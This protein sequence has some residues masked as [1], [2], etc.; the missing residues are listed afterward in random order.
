[1]RLNHCWLYVALLVYTVWDKLV[2]CSSCYNVVAN[3]SQVHPVLWNTASKIV[4]VHVSLADKQE[5]LFRPYHLQSQL[6]LLT[7]CCHEYS[8]DDAT[9]V[10]HYAVQ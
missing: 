1:M 5:E 8:R 3:H 9:A 2:S 7:L 6:P 4:C 10:Q